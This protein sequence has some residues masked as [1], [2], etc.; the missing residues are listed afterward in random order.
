HS[1]SE[2]I[3]RLVVASLARKDIEVA[4]RLAEE[5]IQMASATLA[6]EE[7]HID[8]IFG[9]SDG[10]STGPRPPKL[11]PLVHSI[12]LADFVLSGLRSL[13][14]VVEVDA[15][16]NYVSRLN[17]KVEHFTVTDHSSGNETNT[18]YY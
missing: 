7:K 8:E 15:T 6:E 13:G 1:F 2:Q 11:P 17:G 16:G 4:T 9:K 3:R 12:E 14:S 5:S 18:V 10:A